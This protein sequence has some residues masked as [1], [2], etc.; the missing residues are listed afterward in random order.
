MDTGAVSSH[1]LL[2]WRAQQINIAMAEWKLEKNRFSP[3]LQFGYFNQS[4]ERVNNAQGWIVGASIPLIKTGQGA[5]T[6]FAKLNYQ[7]AQNNLAQTRLEFTSAYKQA[8]QQFNKYNEALQ[9]YQ[10]EGVQLSTALFNTATKSY[11]AGEIGYTEYMHTITQA[12]QIE[13]DYL[14]TVANYN[15]AVIQLNYLLN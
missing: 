1:P 11:T 10:A 5:R 8:V 13:N 12:Y 2:Q 6:Q 7:I 3:S 15:H 4:I 9:Y 14:Q